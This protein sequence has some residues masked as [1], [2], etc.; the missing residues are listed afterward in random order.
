MGRN[1]VHVPF[2]A[3]KL[4]LVLRDSFIGS[5]AK[6]CMVGV[7]FLIEDVSCFTFIDKSEKCIINIL[8]EK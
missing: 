3:S 8:V 7:Y 4:T 6:T 2:R 1:S 5:N